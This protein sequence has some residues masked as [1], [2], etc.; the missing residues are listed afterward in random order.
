MPTQ[1]PSSVSSA[2]VELDQMVIL[3]LDFEGLHPDSHVSELIYIPTVI[4]KGF[5]F[6]FVAYPAFLLLCLLSDGH[7]VWG[8]KSQCCFNLHLRMAKDIEHFSSLLA[9]CNSFESCVFISLAY[10][11]IGLFDILL[12]NLYAGNWSLFRNV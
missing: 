11:F 5:L 8:E 1:S 12:F 10:L 6:F 2:V 9:V 3:S 7:S 4:Y